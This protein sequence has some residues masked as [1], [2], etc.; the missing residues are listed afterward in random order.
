MLLPALSAC[1]LFSTDPVAELAREVFDGDATALAAASVGDGPEI[2]AMRKGELQPAPGTSGSGLGVLAVAP[3]GLGLDP[4]Q[5]AVVFDRAMVPLDG[6]DQA[7]PVRC[8]P[9]IEGRARWAGTS[10]AVIVPSGNR[11]PMATHYACSVPRYTPAADGV[12]LEQE[13]RWEFETERPALVRS[14]P[15]EGAE[16]WDPVEPLVLRFNQPVDPAAV[17]RSLA[18]TTQAGVQ[19]PFACERQEEGRRS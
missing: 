10:T 15:R 18:L 11:F 3:Q 17:A 7:V 6:L 16:E 8:S 14:W 9:A 2:P 1:S 19:V 4:S 13:L 5:V 12:S